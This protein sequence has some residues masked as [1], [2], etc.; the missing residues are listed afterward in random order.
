MAKKLYK[1]YGNC[2]RMGDLSG[3]FVAEEAEIKSSIG[4]TVYFGEV[5]GKHSDISLC[6][7]E[8]DYTELTD[9]L[10]FITKFEAFGC[11]S[12]HNPLDYL[13]EEDEYDDEDDEDEEEDEDNDG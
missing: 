7:S 13:D 6:L 2:G 10:D 5:L 9:D 4:K 8:D 11:Q 1:F 3:L 12:G